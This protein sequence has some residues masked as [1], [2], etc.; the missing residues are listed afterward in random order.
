MKNFKY[1]SNHQKKINYL[2]SQF[3]ILNNLRRSAMSGYGESRFNS[4]QGF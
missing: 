2:K 4:S 3:A 1:E